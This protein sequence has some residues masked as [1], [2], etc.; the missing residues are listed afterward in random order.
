MLKKTG[1]HKRKR[2]LHRPVVRFSKG[3]SFFLNTDYRGHHKFTLVSYFSKQGGVTSSHGGGVIFTKPDGATSIVPKALS[4]Y[5]L[6]EL[7]IKQKLFN[8]ENIS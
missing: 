3:D 7:Y 1:L 4:T 5:S 2:I 8:L 6:G